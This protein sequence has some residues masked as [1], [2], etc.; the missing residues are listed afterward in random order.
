M[1]IGK[2]VEK[3]AK[4]IIF[5]TYPLKLT[6]EMLSTTAN[7]VIINFGKTQRKNLFNMKY[8]EQTALFHR[9]MEISLYLY[10]VSI[11]KQIEEC[12]V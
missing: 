12:F 9:L 8:E 10:L 5:N 1:Y 7:K 11:F 2:V 4:N 6:S 3:N